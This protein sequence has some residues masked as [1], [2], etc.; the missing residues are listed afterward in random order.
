MTSATP[1]PTPEENARL[2]ACVEVGK[3]LTASLRLPEILECIMQQVSRLIEAENWSLLLRDEESGA[4]RFE[5]VVGVDAAL[6]RGVTLPRGVGIAGHVAEHGEPLL[7]PDVHADPRFHREIDRRTG[8]T[9]Q[10]IVCLPLRIRGR[11][12]GVI[13]VINPADMERFAERDLPTLRILADY[14]A[15]ALQNARDVEAIRRLSITDEYTGLYNARYL[16]DLLD[17]MI[18]EKAEE[19]GPLFSLVFADIDNFKRVVDSHGHLLGSQVLKEVGRTMALALGPNDTLVK[20][21]G[22]EYVFVLPGRDK[23][24]ARQL[25]TQILET[26]AATTY[27]ARDPDPVRVTASFGIC[28]Y[29]ADGLSKKE[30]LLRADAALYSVKNSTKNG[31][32]VV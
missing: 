8:F 20:Y 6:L 1:A 22:D 31:V 15:I 23:S 14:A 13:E 12:L 27:L 26:I 32:A 30:I 24:E 4:L 28:T 18:P 16:H 9:S 19:P 7:L 17:Q 3:L 21:G 5:V 25:I 11:V 2:A 29:P 10:S